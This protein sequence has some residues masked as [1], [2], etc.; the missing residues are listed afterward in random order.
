MLVSFYRLFQSQHLHLSLRQALCGSRGAAM[1]MMLLEPVGSGQHP[2][3]S[4]VIAIDHLR[5]PTQTQ[6]GASSKVDGWRRPATNYTQ[7]SCHKQ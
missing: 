1:P 7:Q 3:F 2:Y 6:D 4:Y 5:R